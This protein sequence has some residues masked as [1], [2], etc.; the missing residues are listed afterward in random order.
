MSLWSDVDKRPFRVWE[1]KRQDLTSS[2]NS[3]SSTAST[4]P[5]LAGFG[6]IRQKHSPPPVPRRPLRYRPEPWR[7]IPWDRRGTLACINSHTSGSFRAAEE[8]VLRGGLSSVLTP[9]ERRRLEEWRLVPRTRPS[10]RHAR[11]W[12]LETRRDRI[13][14]S[15]F[16]KQVLLAW[17]LIYKDHFIWKNGD[18]LL[19]VNLYFSQIGSIIAYYYSSFSVIKLWWSDFLN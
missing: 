17:H 15:H 12:S 7:V 10:S 9:A 6:D 18:I 5:Q 2:L 13:K 11:S 1:E 4:G 3:A 16:H 14:L 19:K 8:T